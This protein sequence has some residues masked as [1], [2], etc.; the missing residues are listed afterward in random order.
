MI[1][2]SLG[3]KISF[4][5]TL[6]ALL[7]SFLAVFSLSQHL[8]DQAE[9]AVKERAEILLTVMQAARNYTRDNIQPL[10]D[11]AADSESRDDDGEDVFIR[12]SIPNFA[13]RTIFSDF[14]RQEPEFQDFLY[15]EAALNPT[16]P[17]DQT[18]AFET[19]IFL[20]LQEQLNGQ[21]SD[22]MSEK[23]SG[24]RTLNGE[25]LFYLARPLVMMD[26]KCLDCH[27]RPSQA[28]SHLVD[29]YGS[30]NGFGWKLGDVVAAQMM[31]VPANRIFERGRQNLVTVAKTLFSIL[32]ALVL[33]LNLLL[34]RTVIRPLKILTRT[35]KQISSCSIEQPVPL[36]PGTA[37]G[38]AFGSAFGT[39][40]G[41]A[42]ETETT[43]QFER[44]ALVALTPRRDEPGQL[45]RAFDYMLQVLSQREQD[46]QQAV[47]ERTRSL[48][49][50]MRDRQTAQ[51]ALQIYSHAINH[52]LRN[53]VMGISNVLHVIVH[54]G[55]SPGLEPPG[56]SRRDQTGEENAIEVDPKALAMMQKS[57]DRQLT[58]MNSLMKVQS[59]DVWRMV[60][61]PEAFSLE[62]LLAELRMAYEPKLAATASQLNADIPQ[63]LPLIYAD[64][65][66]VQRIFENL[67]GNALKYNPK[68]VRIT[69]EAVVQA[70]ETQDKPRFIR[71]VVADDGVGIARE[72][73]QDLFQLYARGRQ[74]N[75]ASGHGLGLY[76]CRK[77]VEAHGGEIGLETGRR[78]QGLEIWFTLPLA[79]ADRTASSI[80]MV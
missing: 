57:C 43:A 54:R 14:R 15:K 70:T 20:Q 24:Y 62:Q 66:Q 27:G 68:G 64:A 40:L 39:A 47:R 19:E 30:Q 12:E 2:G 13:A 45:A 76:I 50:E 56:Q 1:N 48:E 37:L 71:C 8:N 49:L 7:G 52:D 69:V 75:K 23:L 35:A 28:P 10:L 67:I 16:N 11:V 58:L 60:L 46:L 78:E 21:S 26:A 18:D 36:A 6:I 63:N 33:V 51:D 74:N 44:Q 65:N 22:R 31:Y 72:K 80:T 61:Q 9:Q 34:R 53:M 73:G 38:S 77:I 5:L 29:M 79:E 59:S 25:K 55:A 41:G 3:K 17:A 4:F 32:G 42:P